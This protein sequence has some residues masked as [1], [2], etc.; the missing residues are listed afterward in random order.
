M[1][2]IVLAIAVVLFFFVRSNIKRGKMF[3]RAYVFLS[4]LD[5]GNSV[6]KANS[7]AVFFISKF[8]PTDSG[9]VIRAAKRYAAEKFGGEQLPV[10][11]LARQRGFT[12]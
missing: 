9:P 7:S 3:A 6:E 8:D 5:D 11:A 10:I 1:T 2:L 4:E 12:G